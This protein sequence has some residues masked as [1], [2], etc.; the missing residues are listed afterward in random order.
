MDQ[1]ISRKPLR[2]GITHGD[3]N[4]IGYEVIMKTLSDARLLEFLTPIVYGSS[5]V[6]S[7]HKKALD[8]SE[9]NFHIVKSA[10]MAQPLKANLVNIC[11]QE[12]KIDLGISTTVAGEMA[13][14]ALETATAD[15]RN[16]LLDALVTAPI[17]KQ[18]IQSSDFQ[19]PG[20]TE[21]LTRKFGADESLM[22]MVGSGLRIGV[23]T[24]HVPLALVPQLITRELVLRKVRLMHQSLLRDFG[25]RG[26]R[27]AILGINPHAGDQGVL[28]TEEQK[29]IVPA[30]RQLFDEGILA[31]GPYPADGFFGTAM[32][33]RFDGV[34]AMYH[35]QGLIPFKAMA[36]RGGVNYTAGLPVV[37]TSPAHGTAYDLAGKNIASPES[38]R[39]AIFLAIDIV[40]NRTLH[41]EISSNPLTAST[42]E[43]DTDRDR[44]ILKDLPENN[45]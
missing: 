24:G 33:A 8:I 39:E 45:E 43:V 23:V 20:H 42:L 17:N 27:I 22:L 14:L 44:N 12:I 9:F 3:V 32:Y 34:L 19:F 29:S 6:A 21:Y 37:R 30:I 36:F 16:G 5:K 10:E 13:Y 18:N 26:P 7:Y 1:S 35:D 28:G 41:R 40:K 38:L 11:T 25:I 2:I 4:G 15:L 31:F